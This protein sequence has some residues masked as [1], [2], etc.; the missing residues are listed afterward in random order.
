MDSAFKPSL[1][2]MEWHPIWQVA[3]G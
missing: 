3:P 2:L 1:A